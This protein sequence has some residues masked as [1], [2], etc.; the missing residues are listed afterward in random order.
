ML[1]FI[2]PVIDYFGRAFV[3]PYVL[4]F[5]AIAEGGEQAKAGVLLL[6]ITL[7]GHFLILLM[8][9]IV[10]WNS[11]FPKLRTVDEYKNRTDHCR[12][13]VKAKPAPDIFRRSKYSNIFNQSEPSDFYWAK[14]KL[15]PLLDIH[16]IRIEKNWKRRR[17]PWHLDI[18]NNAS[19]IIWNPKIQSWQF[20]SKAL[21]RFNDD[22]DYYKNVAMTDVREIADNVLTGVKG[23]YDLIKDKFKLGLSV[24]KV[25]KPPKDDD[26]G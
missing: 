9:K 6:L 14:F 23:D 19:N 7:G 20:E 1:E 11:V 25:I 22:I 10:I 21:E 8:A 3:S 5:N 15:F 16:R 24:Q 4:S 12:I 2:Q 26:D 13:Y 17:W 18:Y